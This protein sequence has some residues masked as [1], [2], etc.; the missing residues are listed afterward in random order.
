MP[1]RHSRPARP[2]A[3]VQATTASQSS[4]AA[5][6]T[7]PVPGSRLMPLVATW[8]TVPSNPS[9]ATTRLLPPPRIRIGSPPPSA[10]QTASIRSSSVPARIKPRAGPPRPTVVKSARFTGVPG[11]RPPGLARRQAHDG[12]GAGQN[13]G[14]VRPGGDVDRHPVAVE[15]LGHGAAHLH[16]GALLVVGHDDRRGEPD[17]VFGDRARVARPLGEE[18][19]RQ[20]HGQHAVRDHVGQAHGPGDALVP[21]DDVEVTGGPGVPDQVPPGH[22]VLPRRDLGAGL[23]LVVAGAGHRSILFPGLYAPRS[24]SVYRAVH[25][26]SPSTVRIWVTVVSVVMLP[27][28]RMDSMVL[29]DT[30]TSPA[31]I[32]RAWVKLCS[33]C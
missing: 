25:T 4:P 16:G 32:G 14:P 10:A 7:S 29:C 31:C 13:L 12:A 30:S 5:T 24:T 21:V 23:D 17:P 6:V 8:M 3:I 9:S 20:G 2:A 22:L 19:A 15:P 1:D 27:T 33:P 11:G 18:P 26:C 28:G